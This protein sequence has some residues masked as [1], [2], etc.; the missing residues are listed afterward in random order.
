MRIIFCANGKRTI[1][2]KVPHI[3]FPQLHWSQ[4][5][6]CNGSTRADG[7][8]FAEGAKCGIKLGSSGDR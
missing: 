4:T 7:H 3:E 1:S 2:G 6:I 8:C 5:G